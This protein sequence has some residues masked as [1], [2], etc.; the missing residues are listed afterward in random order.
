MTSR[1]IF[2]GAWI[3]RLW[4][5]SGCPPD[6]LVIDGFRYTA[7]RCKAYRPPPILVY[8]SW[9]TGAYFC[10]H[11]DETGSAEPG[12]DVVCEECAEALDAGAEITRT[13]GR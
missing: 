2:E 9:N 5:E 11:A 12:H 6:G 1:A 3:F 13:F 10:E 4:K 7:E 8:E